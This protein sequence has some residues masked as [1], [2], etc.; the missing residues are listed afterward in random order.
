MVWRFG[1]LP[2][3]QSPDCQIAQSPNGFNHDVLELVTAEGDQAPADLLPATTNAMGAF[4]FDN[5]PVGVYTLVFEIDGFE[6]RRE[7]R[8]SVLPGLFRLDDVVLRPG[9]SLFEGAAGERPRLVTASPRGRL[10]V[11][12]KRRDPGRG[13]GPS[14]ELV[15]V[16]RR[17]GSS[18]ELGPMVDP[19]RLIWEPD[20]SSVTVVEDLHVV[21]E[22]GGGERTTLGNLVRYRPGDDQAPDGERSLLDRGVLASTVQSFDDGSLVFAQDDPATPGFERGALRV[23][24]QGQPAPVLL[25]EGVA[26]PS[27]SLGA[28]G[29]VGYT[30][31]RGVGDPGPVSDMVAEV[32]SM[33]PGQPGGW[34]AKIV[35][36]DLADDD[37]GAFA[38]QQGGR[39][40]AF[41]REA[42]NGDTELAVADLGVAQPS[43]AVDLASGDACAAGPVVFSGERLVAS[44]DCD[45]DG[46]GTLEVVDVSPAA[47]GGG[48]LA[49]AEVRADVYLPAVAVVEE[50]DAL[51]LAAGVVEDGGG[52]LNGDV[53]VY[54]LRRIGEVDAV[55]DVDVEVMDLANNGLGEAIPVGVA[56]GEGNE[57]ERVVLV[58][59]PE[60][61][62]I[63][64]QPIE[65][66]AQVEVVVDEGASELVLEAELEPDGTLTVAFMAEESER[67]VDLGDDE[68]LVVGDLMLAD[69]VG[70][71]DPA[72]VG[73]RVPVQAVELIE[74][75]D[76]ADDDDVAVGVVAVRDVGDDGTGELVVV[77]EAGEEESIATEVGEVVVRQDVDEDTQE[78]VNVIA[79]GADDGVREVDLVGPAI[80][81]PQ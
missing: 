59:D 56:E 4:S 81:P 67:V 5:L 74:V 61:G 10:V 42:D 77:D 2:N 65:V 16:D 24:P 12:E 43:R 6:P 1:K 13:R 60:S 72:E 32:S 55:A 45:E 63:V 8:V 38:F 71:N 15:L 80:L 78:A 18:I 54:D 19:Q 68:E 21:Q 64:A 14:S 66:G 35:H 69:N 30:R 37:V 41:Q 31:D 28:E 49:G 51:V 22:P 48:A 9:R 33:R 20:E 62:A 76:E 3:G 57:E 50:A 53:E 29:V 27:I 39:L 23:L 47:M 79:F 25:A 34:D 44:G 73:A 26:T 52:R 58:R 36:A 40:V 46:V 75:A 11:L 70:D 7:E 17:T